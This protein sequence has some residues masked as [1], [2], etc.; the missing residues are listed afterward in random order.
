MHST[1]HAN[2]TD[3]GAVR[4]NNEDYAWS[5]INKYNNMA[6]IICDG[7][8]GYKGG[9]AASEITVN[10][11]CER[12]VNTDLS[13]YNNEQ[14]YNWMA[15]VIDAARAQIS[16]HIKTNPKLCNMATTLVCALVINLKAYI[17]NIGDSRCWLIDKNG[18]ASQITLDQNLYN[19]LTAINAPK[20]TFLKHH[21]NLYAITQFVGAQTKKIIKPDIFIKTLTKGEYLILTS[22]GCHNFV[23][24][25][26]IWTII[27]F[28]SNKLERACNAVISKALSNS[29]NDNLSIVILGV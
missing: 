8:G 11:F 22:D 19:Y 15:N 26:K 28:D 5:G 24:M 6:G 27:K 16:E 21:D 2:L 13:A 9:S 14:I 18:E 25:N 20:E 3:I 23:N 29:S 12:F 17:F 4:Q 10:V 7:L 1:K